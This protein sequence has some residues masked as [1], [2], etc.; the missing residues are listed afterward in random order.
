MRGLSSRENLAPSVGGF[1]AALSAQAAGVLLWIVSRRGPD[2][3][4]IGH[5]RVCNLGKRLH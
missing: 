1:R 3:V 4:C 5:D 2:E